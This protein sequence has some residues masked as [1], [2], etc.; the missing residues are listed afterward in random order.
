MSILSGMSSF[1]S[2]WELWSLVG[3]LERDLDDLEV[4]GERDGLLGGSGG[5]LSGDFG[6]G[7]GVSSLDRNSGCSCML[8]AM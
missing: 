2:S 4:L 6:G 3:V 5:R 1:S 8:D 7:G